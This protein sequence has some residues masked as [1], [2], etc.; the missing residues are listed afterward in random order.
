MATIDGSDSPQ[1]F[2]YRPLPGNLS[3]RQRDDYLQEIFVANLRSAFALITIKPPEA[4]HGAPA[5]Q[6]QHNR[7]SVAFNTVGNP[8]DAEP[9]YR[10]ADLVVHARC[11]RS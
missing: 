8:A 5:E 1:Y 11:D 10:S 6:G 9:G 7:P 4:D 2:V 3:R